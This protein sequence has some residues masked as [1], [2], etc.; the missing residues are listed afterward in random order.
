LVKQIAETL[1]NNTLFIKPKL[2]NAH[3]V[4]DFD[5]ISLKIDAIFYFID[6]KAYF[7]EF[8]DYYLPK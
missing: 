1:S 2:T 6:S 4:I 5:E 7:N 3:E 8:Y